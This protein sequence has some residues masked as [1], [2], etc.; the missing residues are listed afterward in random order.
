[1]Q[2]RIKKSYKKDS[3]EE[4]FNDDE[5]SSEDKVPTAVVAT[6]AAQF[7]AMKSHERRSKENTL[8]QLDQAKF[9]ASIVTSA[10]NMAKVS[11]FNSP[12]NEVAFQLSTASSST[13]GASNLAGSDNLVNKS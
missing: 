5:A 11:N 4:P 1:M 2:K 7:A 6:S 3:F 12:T 13:T 8:T 10:P 9:K